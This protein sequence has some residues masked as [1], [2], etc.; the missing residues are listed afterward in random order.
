[1]VLYVQK[2]G[3]QIV[4]NGIDQPAALKITASQRSSIVLIAFVTAKKLH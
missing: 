2:G 3:S 4:T 1:M